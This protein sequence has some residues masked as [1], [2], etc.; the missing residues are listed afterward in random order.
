MGLFKDKGF[1]VKVLVVDG[2]ELLR[3]VLK[4]TLENEGYE[5]HLAKDGQESYMSL[6]N[7][8]FDA[9]LIN[10]NLDK[11]TGLHIIETIRKIPHYKSVPII[12]FLDEQND[13]NEKNSLEV[14]SDECMVK[15]L[16]I[17]KLLDTLKLL[18]HKND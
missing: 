2:S 7:N 11:K 16:D 12:T 17:K 10:I 3:V 6:M 5:V 4:S 18:L 14:G 1:C 9:L 8:H 15:P 13:S